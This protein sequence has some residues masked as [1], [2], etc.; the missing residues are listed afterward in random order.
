LNLAAGGD[1]VRRRLFQLMESSLGDG[2][3]LVQLFVE[4]VERF[5]RFPE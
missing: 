2:G 5:L 1:P 4:R 3:D